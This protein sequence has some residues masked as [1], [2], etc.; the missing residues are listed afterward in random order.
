MLKKVRVNAHCQKM[1][2][3]RKKVVASGLK[4]GDLHYVPVI[5]AKR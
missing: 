2:S 5:S 4:A 3:L 1:I